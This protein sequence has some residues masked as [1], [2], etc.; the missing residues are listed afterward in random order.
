MYSM[1]FRLKWKVIFFF[2]TKHIVGW[3]IPE[4][5]KSI[6]KKC[7]MVLSFD[8]VTRIRIKSLRVSLNESYGA[9]LVCGTI[10]YAVQGGSN[11]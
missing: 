2:M 6:V 11:F 10:Y 5:P 3:L 7:N 9:V 8:S 1:A 4:I